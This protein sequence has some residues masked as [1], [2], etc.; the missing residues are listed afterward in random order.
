MRQH[1]SVRVEI[2]L[3]VICAASYIAFVRLR[4]AMDRARAGGTEVRSVIR[5]FQLA[6]GV[7]FHGE[8]LLDFLTRRF[9]EH[10]RPELDQ[11]AAD[12]LR[13]GVVLDYGRAVAA[14]T[15]EA[16]RLIASADARGRGEAMTER[17]FRA[18]FT[19]GLDISDEG[20][21]R[22]LAAEVGVP[23]NDAS[24]EG[25]RLELTWVRERGVRAVPVFTFGGGAPMVG[26]RDESVYDGA[27]AGETSRVGGPSGASGA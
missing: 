10:V 16:H 24:E 23:A 25:L 27:L 26:V 18:H 17:L 14:G 19:D 1:Q 20:V 5:P 9:G 6:P 22:E 11:A 4:R 15:F 12:A 21:L 3:D 13:D 7:D 8:P 2:V